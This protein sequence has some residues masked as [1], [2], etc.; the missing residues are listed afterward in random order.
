MRKALIIANLGGFVDFLHGDI[1]ILISMGYEVTYAANLSAVE[2]ERGKKKLDEKGI[3]YNDICFDSQNPFSKSNRKAYKQLKELLKN[4]YDLIHCHT[5]IVGVLTKI[6]A[7]S[8]RKKGSKVIY[9]THGFAFTEKSGIKSWAVFYTLEKLTSFLCD[10]IITI[11]KEDYKVAKNMFCK[12]VYYI[13][14]MG[15]KTG[16][17]QNV[18]ID[19]DEYRK[20]IGVNPEQLMI[21]SLGELSVRK[22]HQVIVKAI[23]SLPDK[24]RYIYVICGVGI[25]GGTGE[26]IQSL[27]KELGV[28]VILLGYRYDIPEILY[29]SDIGALPSIREGLGLAG[30]QSL[31]AGVPIVATAVQGIKDYV[32]DGKTG[33]LSSAFDVKGFAEGIRKLSNLE[34]RKNMTRACVEKA[35]EFDESISLSQRRRIYEMELLK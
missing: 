19:R 28:H 24:E 29:C 14:G 4:Q 30:V 5:P 23:A 26:M 12:H 35:K 21:L 18:Q 16:I 9:T 17:Y 32:I 7:E 13:N 20:S 34:I 25:N 1:D 31:A 33:Y 15:V 6:A 8:Y 10:A 27:A 3:R 2:W 11:N 22:N